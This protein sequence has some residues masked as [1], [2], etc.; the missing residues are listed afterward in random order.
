MMAE[1]AWPDNPQQAWDPA[2]REKYPEAIPS[3]ESRTSPPIGWREVTPPVNTSLGRGAGLVA[4]GALGVPGDVLS[5]VGTG[6]DTAREIPAIN[7]LLPHMPD[8]GIPNPT[9]DY[10]RGRFEMAPPQGGLERGLDVT[11]R[12]IGTAAL[13]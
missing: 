11:G 7:R 2:V 6:I 3:I 1:D 5:A 8:I 4:T 9:T 10:I 13:A 12:A